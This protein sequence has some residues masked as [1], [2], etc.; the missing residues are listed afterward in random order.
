M[1]TR[2]VYEKI[3]EYKGKKKALLLTGARQIGK[4]SIAREFGKK[5]YKQLIEINFLKDKSAYEALKDVS[6][7]DEL[8]RVLS[9]FAKEP[10]KKGNT[11]FL[12]D[13]V[14]EIPDLLTH[15]KF[16]VE[17]GR[18]DYILTGSLLGVKLKDIRSIPVGFMDTIE[19]YPLDFEEFCMANGIQQDVFKYL[20]EQ[21]EKEEPINDFIHKKLMMLFRL[22]LIVGGMP[23]AVQT[24]VNT[25]DLNAV[26]QVQKNIIETYKYDIAKYDANNKLHLDEI[27]ES[28][29]SELNSKNKRF[30][31]KK[32][33]EN[34]RFSKYENSFEWLKHAG[35]ALPTYIAEEP[36]VPLTLSKKVNL[37]KLFMN[38][39][40][41]LASL[42]ETGDLQLKLLKNELSINNGAIFE[43]AVAQELKAHGFNLYYYASKKLGEI[44]FLIEHSDKI[45]PIEVKSGARY[46]EHTALNNV[47]NAY[48]LKKGLVF[49]DCNISKSRCVTYYPVYMLMFL[50]PKELPKNL[51]YKVDLSDLSKFINK[52]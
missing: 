6:D 5:K 52:K 32:L 49:A 23:E 30:I 27:L 18:Y 29:P 9:T 11:L 1:L 43:N 28:I 19:M 26:A 46:Q 35:V 12:F 24:Y 48:K 36:K 21:Y 8:L 31:L 25:N 3:C 33:N 34:A 7:T 13:E 20:K 37:F 14:Q 10:L 39:V 44:D 47:M 51:I 4:S 45:L 40:G 2:K 50:R 15:I 38:D 41:L 22:Y 16:L 42:Y 17:D